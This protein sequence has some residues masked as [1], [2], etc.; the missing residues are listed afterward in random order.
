MRK[1][2][3]M[4]EMSIKK[5]DINFFELNDNKHETFIKRKIDVTFTKR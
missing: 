3:K 4:N 1:K 2:N 5:N